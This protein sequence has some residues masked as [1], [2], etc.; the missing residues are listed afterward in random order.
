MAHFAAGG[1]A[2]AGYEREPHGAAVVESYDA[3]DPPNRYVVYIS[4]PLPNF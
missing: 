4:R 1:D 2:V 3:V